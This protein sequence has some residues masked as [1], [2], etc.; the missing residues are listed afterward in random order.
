MLGIEGVRPKFIADYNVLMK[1]GEFTGGSCFIWNIDEW[2]DI[3]D[4]LIQQ[5]ELVLYNRLARETNRLGG[6]P[7]PAGNRILLGRELHNRLVAR[8]RASRP[9]P[10][11]APKYINEGHKNYRK[12]RLEPVCH[13]DGR[14]RTSGD[15]YAFEVLLNRDT[16]H[17]A[18]YIRYRNQDE[19]KDLD[20]S[21]I[22][23]MIDPDR[24]SAV[25][26]NYWHDPSVPRD[27]KVAAKAVEAEGDATGGV[28]QTDAKED[29]CFTI[30]VNQV[31]GTVRPI[32]ELA[33]WEELGRRI[34]E[35]HRA[36]LLYFNDED[37][38][39]LKQP[40]ISQQYLVVT[41]ALYQAMEAL[42]RE[43]AD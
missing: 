8:M 7:I 6:K 26:W 10:F 23:A 27:R 13:A 11:H 40:E 18:V 14:L 25:P 31:F 3:P 19:P 16:G 37:V 30:R 35:E 42:R 4:E 9:E 41:E 36:Y 24:L 5:N 12:T 28:A 20:V 2:N 38:Q 34:R 29:T 32:W 1:K 22:R 39:D 15:D 17:L 33:V 43:M 21:G